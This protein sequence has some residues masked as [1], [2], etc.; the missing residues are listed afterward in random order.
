[1]RR[2]KGA[3]RRRGMVITPSPTCLNSPGS[4]RAALRPPRG[5]GRIVLGPSV[6]PDRVFAQ[7]N[8]DTIS[9]DRSSKICQGLLK[10]RLGLGRR[11]IDQARGMLRDQM[12]ERR[13]LSQRYR[14][15]PEP[16]SEIDERE[17]K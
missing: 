1:M 10:P 15:G 11:A 9:L 17:R 3:A 12:L 13:P 5:I 4:E 6:N 7:H 14:S 2:Q 8:V 16:S